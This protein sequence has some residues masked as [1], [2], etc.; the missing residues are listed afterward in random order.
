VHATPECDCIRIAFVSNPYT[1]AP[2]V[3]FTTVEALFELIDSVL[4]DFLTVIHVSPYQFEIIDSR[5]E[6]QRRGFRFRRYDGNSEV[7]FIT[8]PTGPHEKL[9]LEL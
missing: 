9:H 8:I 1:E 2:I 4:G 5:R 3:R 6:S 7:L